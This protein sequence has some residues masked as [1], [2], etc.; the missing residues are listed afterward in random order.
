MYINLIYLPLFN[1]AYLFFLFLT[2]CI[3]GLL[4]PGFRV[5]FFLLF[6]FCPP[7][8]GPVICVSFV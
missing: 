2:Y 3:W 1:F 6:G 4:F 5:E 8:V 7:K